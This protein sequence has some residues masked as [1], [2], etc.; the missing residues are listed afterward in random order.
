MGYMQHS[1]CTG[2]TFPGVFGGHLS[3]CGMHWIILSWTQLDT[4]FVLN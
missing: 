3:E 4:T 2:L 1:G